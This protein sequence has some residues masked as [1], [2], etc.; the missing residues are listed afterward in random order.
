MWIFFFPVAGGDTGSKFPAMGALTW[1]DPWN[2]RKQQSLNSTSGEKDTHSRLKR[3]CTKAR[4]GSLSPNTS[5]SSSNRLHLHY[6]DPGI[7]QPCPRI[8]EYPPLSQQPVPKLCQHSWSSN[9]P[10][11]CCPDGVPVIL[12]CWQPIPF[13][14]HSLAARTLSLE[15]LLMPAP[16]LWGQGVQVTHSP[17]GG[18]AEP[19][20]PFQR[21]GLSPG[22]ST[23]QSPGSLCRA[24]DVKENGNTSCSGVSPHPK[25]SAT[26]LL[27]SSSAGESQSSSPLSSGPNAMQQLKN[28][29]PGIPFHYSL[30][31]HP[32]GVPA[33]HC[34]YGEGSDANSREKEFSWRLRGE[35]GCWMSVCGTQ[36]PTGTG[37]DSQR[38]L[39][40]MELC[41]AGASPQP[42]LPGVLETPDG[43]EHRE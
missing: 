30:C 10:F 29:E 7:L 13:Y 23:C 42:V 6:N 17:L 16:G 40:R 43:T 14:L 24:W 33:F 12:I 18:E 27:R 34:R 4:F 36:D 8:S 28:S 5:F 1:Q 32:L 2:S 41:W 25:L 9:H 31:S 3:S 11:N 26:F 22:K 20:E 39:R 37:K 19:L 15:M 21:L 35:G 38:E